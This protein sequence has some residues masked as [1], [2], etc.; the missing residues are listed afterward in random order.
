MNALDVSEPAAIGQLIGSPLPESD[1]I[2]INQEQV[3]RFADVSGDHQWIHVDTERAAAESP[4]GQTIVHGNLLLLVAADLSRLMLT[5]SY[6]SRQV[7]YGFD[8]I[9][10]LT[11]VPVGCRVRL[12][13]SLTEQELRKDGS[14]RLVTAWTLELEGAERPALI[15]R[16]IK[17][18]YP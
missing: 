16:S 15:A 13:Q 14:I 9:R 2:T 1:W 10:F 11:P 12:L 17:L 5:F 3:N 6:A 4:Y 7:N 8:T 18:V